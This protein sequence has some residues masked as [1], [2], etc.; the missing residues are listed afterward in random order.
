MTDYV[1]CIPSYKRADICNAQTLATLNSLNIDKDRVY[2]FVANR[3]EYETYN[4]VL[5]KDFYHKIV[6]GVLGIVQQRLFISRE[7]IQYKQ[8]VYVDDDIKKIDFSLSEY[9]DHTL[10]EFIEFAFTLCK[11]S[12]SFIW[13]VYPVY[14]PYF[15]KDRPEV[16]TGLNFIIGCFYGVINRPW[17]LETEI[18]VALNGCKDDVENS[19]LYYKNDGIVIRF[20]RIGFVTKIYN[21]TGGMGNFKSRIEPAKIAAENLLKAYPEYGKIKTRKN[22]MIEF[23]LHKNVKKETQKCREPTLNNGNS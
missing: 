4:A 7:F 17:S 23:V 11:K 6:I 10:H 13:G 18:K 16:S 8:I 22:G 20:N 1:I 15:R 12:G 19:I 3:A 5:N 14:N 2:V 21:N 9:K